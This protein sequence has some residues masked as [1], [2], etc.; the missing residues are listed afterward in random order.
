VK[1][2]YGFGFLSI[3]MV[4]AGA[5]QAASIAVVNSSFE[6]PVLPDGAVGAAAGWTAAGAA[7]AH[8]PTAT[9]LP[10][11]PPDGAQVL[12]L[13]GTANA[14]QT[15]GAVLT[16]GTIYTL[17]V[18]VGSRADFNFIFGY[19]INLEDGATVL[20]SA[21]SPIPANGSFLTASIQYMALAGDPNLGQPLGIRLSNVPSGSSTAFMDNVRLD[22]SATGV[23]EPG[24]APLLPVLALAAIT[25]YRRRIRSVI[26]GRAS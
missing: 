1:L 10:G 14:S 9:E 6:L 20:A 24:Y 3:L 22:A 8:N 11:G 25:V 17:L 16:A 21:N 5:G 18:D 4:F 13:Q 12:F 26:A 15:L 7:F 23:P 2:R 19:Q